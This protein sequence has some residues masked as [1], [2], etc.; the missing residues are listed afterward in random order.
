M[1]TRT[2]TRREDMDSPTG[3]PGGIAPPVD[4][5]AA[6]VVDQIRQQNVQMNTMGRMLEEMRVRLEAGDTERADMQ[7]QRQQDLGRIQE[8]RDQAAAAVAAAT[9][10]TRPRD[11]RMFD[12][13]GLNKPAVFDSS[14]A[15]SFPLWSFKFANYFASIHEKAKLVLEYCKDL[16]EEVTEADRDMLR[17]DVSNVE[18]LSA[19][20]Y[21]AL[22]SLCDGEALTLVINTRSDDGLEAWRRITKRFDPVGPGRKRASLNKIL[23]PGACKIHELMQH[24]ETWK[25][26]VQKY[27]SRNKSKLQDDIKASVITEMCPPTLKDH[28]YLNSSRLGTYDEVLAEITAFAENKSA[29]RDVDAMDVGYLGGKGGKGGKGRGGGGDK[30]D[31]TCFN[32]GKT[33]HVAR[34]CRSAPSG[35]GGGY[36]G[37]GKEK[38][39]SQDSETF[40]GYCSHCLRW[41]HRLAKCRGKAAG[42]AAV[43]DSAGLTGMAAVRAK[44]GGGA[45]PKGKSKGKAKGKG[46]GKGLGAL[47][48]WKDEEEYWQGAEPEQELGGVDLCAVDDSSEFWTTAWRPAEA[49]SRRSR[50]VRKREASWI[51]RGWILRGICSEEKKKQEVKIGP[52]PKVRSSNRFRALAQ[53]EQQEPADLAAIDPSY[54]MKIQATVDSGAALNVMPESWFQDYPLRITKEN[55]KKYRAANGQLIKDEGL[56]SLNAVVR[57]G[58]R[59]VMRKV[60]CRVTQVNKMLLAVSKI[61][62]A[63]NKVQFSEEESFI[64][65]TKSKEKLPLRRENGVYVLDLEVMSAGTKVSSKMLSSVTDSAH[66]EPDFTRQA[67]RKP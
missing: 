50:K 44:A 9:G 56:R 34:E 6:A 27:E 39:K 13:K 16:T 31:W 61:V 38:G 26:Q 3:P 19:D 64:Q 20:L 36:G 45:A 55:G 14:A 37:K 10:G 67:V 58:N 17:H 54:T 51:A 25:D 29:A 35:G 15:K 48:E 23:S 63:G 8:L 5:T 24:L 52:V 65:N 12:S 32:C 33:G 53:Q 28:I 40:E 7:G 60:N 46:K 43:A 4:D 62:D 47:D 66:Q 11:D 22:A 1:Q 21:M 59:N 49:S 57:S 30:S 18:K 42:K 41:G 2:R